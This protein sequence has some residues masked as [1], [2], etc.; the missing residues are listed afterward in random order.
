MGKNRDLFKKIWDN[1]GTFPAKMGTVKER[2]NIDLTEA[3]GIK[4]RLQ[5]YT[6]EPQKRFSWPI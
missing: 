2:N 6:K 1:K 5:E 3:E 4:K